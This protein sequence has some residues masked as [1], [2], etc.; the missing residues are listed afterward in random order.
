M[1]NIAAL[2]PQPAPGPRR[3]RAVHQAR[4]STGCALLYL[5]TTPEDAT[6]MS[7]Q[8]NILFNTTLNTRARANVLTRWTCVRVYSVPGTRRRV[9]PRSDVLQSSTTL[10][11]STTCQQPPSDIFVILI[12]TSRKSQIM[13]P[14]NFW[15]EQMKI[16][17]RPPSPAPRVSTT[18]KL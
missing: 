5:V 14:M 1:V 8:V 16:S 11:L 10:S 18:Q 15:T 6:M 12:R 7:S 2:Q 17:P 9:D 13:A 4:C 3:G